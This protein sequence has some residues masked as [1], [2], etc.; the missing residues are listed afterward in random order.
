MKIQ[1]ENNNGHAVLTLRGDFTEEEVDRFRKKAVEQMDDKT[2]DF[3]LDMTHVPY[4]DSKG[5]ESLLWLQEQCT[6]QL[7]QVRLAACTQN[8]KTILRITRLSDVITACVDVEEA[9]KSLKA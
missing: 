8:V 5:L 3:V 9:I 6:E 1:S 7:G 4:V 2:H